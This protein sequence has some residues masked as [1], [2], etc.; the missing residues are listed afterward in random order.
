MYI[1]IKE[2][3]AL[4]G[5]TETQQATLFRWLELMPPD[6]VLERIAKPPPEGFGIETHRNTLRRFHI[7]YESA[8]HDDGE[9][10]AEILAQ[11][12]TVLAG[13]TTA[14][15]EKLAFRLATSPGEKLSQF[16][17]LARWVLKLKEHGQKADLLALMNRRLELD[18]EKFRFNAAR[19]ALIHFV[20]LKEIAQ[21]QEMDD[22]DK[23]RAARK[24][25]FG[26]PLPL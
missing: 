20:E 22:E 11:P 16:K 17:A 8:L 9:L 23:V 14:R 13:A 26:E 2:N 18:V 19:S 15:V 4:A 3:S 7:K 24:K 21:N 1:P 10:A 5:L 12:Q 25:M 6:Q